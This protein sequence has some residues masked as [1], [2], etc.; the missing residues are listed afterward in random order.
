VVA[1][2]GDAAEAPLR[3]RVARAL[4]NKGVALGA[5]GRS[6]EAVRARPL[7]CQCQRLMV[8]VFRVIAALM[9]SWRRVMR[10]GDGSSL[11]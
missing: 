11:I 6:E 2:F 5:L 9:R 8:K 1:R 3:E 10:L 7:L 4:V